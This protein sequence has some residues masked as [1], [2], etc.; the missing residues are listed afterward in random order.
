MSGWGSKPWGGGAFGNGGEFVPGGTPTA[1]TTSAT[2]TPEDPLGTDIDVLDDLPPTFRLVSG[3]RNLANA[4]A[5][6]LSTPSGALAIFGGDP[7]YGFDLR[8]KMNS[9]WTQEELA[10]L[11]SQVESECRKDERVEG[12][13]VTASHNLSTSTLTVDAQIESAEGPFSLILKVSDVGIELLRPE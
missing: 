9:S 2:I 8:D 5:R 12:A 13:T 1:P 11:G 6:R 7:E 4:L 3:Q 10:A